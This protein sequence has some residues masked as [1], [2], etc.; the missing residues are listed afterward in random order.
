IEPFDR[1]IDVYIKFLNSIIASEEHGKR[2]EKA[3]ILLKMYKEASK[4]FRLEIEETKWRDRS[5]LGSYHSRLLA[6]P[7]N[8]SDLL[9]CLTWP[10]W[11]PDEPRNDY[12]LARKWEMRKSANDGSV[13]FY[14]PSMTITGNSVVKVGKEIKRTKY[15]TPPRPLYKVYNLRPPTDKTLDIKS[16]AKKPYYIDYFIGLG[17]VEW[18]L[19]EDTTM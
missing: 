14:N 2:P 5:L 4:I 17:N 13:Y 9:G 10:A 8:P 1:K 11:L 6:E 16:T 12:K 3:R 18:E 19:M 15:T 7:Q